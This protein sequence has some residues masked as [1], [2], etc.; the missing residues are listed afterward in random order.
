MGNASGGMTQHQ[1]VR[2][3]Q[4]HVDNTKYAKLKSDLYVWEPDKESGNNNQYLSI[5]YDEDQQDVVVT[6]K[7]T[8]NT[9][10]SYIA[11][12]LNGFSG[13]YATG[14]INIRYTM[15]SPTK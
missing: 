14:A 12:L 13:N 3:G 4:A 11:R 8:Y 6:A 15:Y 2:K 7:A 10:S 1:I 5:Y 9:T